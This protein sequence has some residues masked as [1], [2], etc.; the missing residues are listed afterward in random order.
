MDELEHQVWRHRSPNLSTST[1]YYKSC[2]S[3]LTKEIFQT[4]VLV[5]NPTS[6]YGELTMSFLLK[7]MLVWEIPNYIIY[8]N[9][10][11]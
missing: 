10:D 2:N 7:T 3:Y 8:T 6:V 1:L 4:I 11:I 9:C 5:V